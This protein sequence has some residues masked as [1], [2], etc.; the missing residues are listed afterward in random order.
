MAGFCD[1]RRNC[2]NLLRPILDV[3]YGYL[4]FTVHTIDGIGATSERPAD[5]VGVN[6]PVQAPSPGS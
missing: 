6:L 1:E 3:V 5:M 2:I 4:G